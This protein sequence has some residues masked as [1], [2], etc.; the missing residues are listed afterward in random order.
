MSQ[1]TIHHRETTLA[2][3]LDNIC[4]GIDH[5]KDL[6]ELIPDSPFPARGLV[7]ALGYLVTLGNVKPF[8]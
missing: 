2:R 3:V 6:V 7:K 5:G 8:D 4:V 1:W